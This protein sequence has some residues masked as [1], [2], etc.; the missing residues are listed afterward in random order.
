MQEEDKEE[1]KQD[2]RDLID[3]YDAYLKAK[4]EQRMEVDD[5]DDADEEP[6]SAKQPLNY[7][8]Q[9]LD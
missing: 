1:E 6:M 9:N 4:A 5:R 8:T 2:P 3:E 7:F